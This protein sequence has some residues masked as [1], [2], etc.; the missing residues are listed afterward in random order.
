MFSAIGKP[1]DVDGMIDSEQE[2]D[3]EKETVC[4]RSSLETSPNGKFERRSE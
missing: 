4:K 1:H 2:D 3:D